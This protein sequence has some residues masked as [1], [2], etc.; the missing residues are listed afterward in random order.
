MTPFRRL[1]AGG[2]IDRTDERHLS[3]NGRAYKG[4][5]G[6]TLASALLAGGATV[7]GRSFKL[8][9]PRA[10][11]AAGVE[12][13]NAIVTVGRGAH[14][15]P[16]LKAT[17]VEVYDGLEARSVNVWPSAEFDL[18][19]VAGRLFGRFLPGGFYY[20]TFLWPRWQTWEPFVR[21]AAGLG[22]AP[23]QPDPETYE[24]FH[25]HCDVLVVGGGPAGL[26]AALAA[27]RA[28]ARVILAEMDPAFGGALLGEDAEID[29][30]DAASWVAW[31]LAEL[32]SMPDVTLLPRTTVFGAYDHGFFAA[33]ERLQ[34]HLPPRVRRGPRQRLWKIRARQ[35]VYAQGAIER[36]VAFADNDRPGVMLAGA[37]RTYA[38]RFAVAPAGRVVVFTATDAGYATALDLARHGCTVAAIIDS[39]PQADGPLVRQ[40]HRQGLRV[41]AGALVGATQGRG[42][43]GSVDIVPASGHGYAER[44]PCD[45]LAVSGGWTPTVHLWAQS[46]GKLDWSDE[47]VAFLPGAGPAHLHPAGGATT[48]AALASGFAAGIRAARAAGLNGAVGEAPQAVSVEHGRPAALWQ[49]PGPGKAWVDFQNDVTTADIALAARENYRSVE[50]LKRY[51]T[52]GMAVDQGKT[53]NVVALALMGRETG[54]APAEV[55]TTRYRPPFDPVSFGTIAGLNRGALYRP[56]LRLPAEAVHVGLKAHFADFGPWWRPEFYPRE[57][58]SEEA[59]IRREVLATREAVSV[60]DASPLGKIEVSGRDAGLFLD[61][62]YVQTV[63]TIPVGRTR[64]VVMV[65][66]H[67]VVADDG[68]ITRLAGD[69]FLVGTTSGN[70]ARVP[71][72]FEEWLQCEWPDLDVWVVPVTEQWAVM[73][74]AGPKARDVLRALGTDI[75]LAPDA[76]PHLAYREGTVAGLTARVARVSFTG[77]L[78]YEVSVHARHA[79]VFLRRILEAGAPHGITPLGVESLL[80][81]RLEKG[82]IHVGVDTDGTTLPDDIG[83]ARGVAKKA[84]DFAG[85]RSLTRP[86]GVDPNRLQLVGLLSADTHTLLPAGAQVLGASG[87]DGHVTSSV[88]SPTLGHPVALGMVRAGRARLGENVDVLS[89][90]TRIRAKLVPPAFYDPKGE[91]LHG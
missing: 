87:S 79:E 44:L 9:R 81:L 5:G 50:H 17:L 76:F 75:D 65:S 18:T 71:L 57:G 33:A 34:D 40:A 59:A 51:T 13:P 20:K 61:R 48:A 56:R 49:V 8:H 21:R 19:G 83:M 25:A 91:R 6:D 72:I 64:Y 78:S 70:A 14:E 63:S 53:S 90:G 58:E 66:E 30:Q 11:M 60:L 24:P 85:R 67:G 41:H 38:N 74:L 32:A 4:F 47:A 45:L 36:P 31:A 10:V 42:W 16:N 88:L 73:T 23:A 7:V 37:V 26:G 3:F 28:G 35:A 62:M 82:F 80:V 46:G 12:E 29:G 84:S 52:L 86:A 39:R 22:E 68:V 55:G 54:R 2:R 15:E 77:E 27:G 43:V 1:P 89:G 69:R